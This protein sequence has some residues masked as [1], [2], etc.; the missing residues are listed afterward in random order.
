MKPT[1][2]LLSGNEALAL[3]AIDG[4]TSAAFGYPGTPSTEI[5]ENLARHA[6]PGLYC[7][8]S[9]NEKVALEAAAGAA[10][11]GGRSIVTMKH[12]GL[13]VA[14]DPLM[15]LSYIGVVGG[16]VI[17]VADDPG[18]HSSQTEQ[19]TRHYARLAKVPILEPANAQEAYDFLREGFEISEKY[20]CPVILRTTTC[21]S[22]SRCLVARAAPRPQNHVQFVR[23]PPQFVPLPIWGRKLRVGIEERLDAQAAD[24]AR[25]TTLNTILPAATA[26]CQQPLPTAP[27]GIV[28]SGV[29]ALHAREIFPDSPMLKL[30]WAFPF[31]D[32]LIRDFAATVERLLVIEEGDPILEEHIRALGIACDGKNLVPRCGELTPARIA[33]SRA[34]LEGRSANLPAPVPEAADLPGRPPILCAGCPHRALFHALARFDVVVS[35]DI[36]CYSLGVFPPLNQTDTILCM[37]GGFTVAHGMTQAGEPRR[38]VGIVGDSTFFHSGITGLLNSVYNQSPAK[39]IVV[40]NRITAMTGHQDHPGTGTTLMGR[41]T[42]AASIEALAAACGLERIRV[43]NPYDQAALHTILEEELAADGPSLIISRAPCPL[44]LKRRIAPQRRIDP[45]LCRNC[46]ACLKCGC[47]AIESPDKTAKPRINE[48]ACMGCSLCQALCKFGAIATRA[49]Q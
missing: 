26:D 1:R 18:Q 25:R 40:D 29:A 39:L 7:E 6:A 34:R 30:G 2:Q 12:V 31:P 27:L 13:N 43:C 11:A 37:G 16:M 48:T 24:A 45:D 36:G 44:H 20:R 21:V 17:C 22:H 9:P 15:T 41:S 14:A 8:W 28:S 47:P 46:R 33:E 23:N 10:L 38:V 42:H 4:G 32:G 49:G 3:A 35:G 19:D 5:L